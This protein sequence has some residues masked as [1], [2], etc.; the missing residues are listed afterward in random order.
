[1]LRELQPPQALPASVGDAQ[2]HDDTYDYDAFI[3]YSRKDRVF[4]QLL[5]GRLEAY[6]PPKSLGLPARPLRV[7]LDTSDIRGPDYNETIERELQRS[8][9]LI[10]VC[11]PAARASEFVQDEIRRFIAAKRAENEAPQI[12]PLLLQGIPNNEAKTPEDEARKAFPEALYEVATMPLAQSFL[13]FDPQRHKLDRGGYRDAWFAA[14]A[15]LLDVDRHELEERDA[16]RAARTRRIITG[17]TLFTLVV[18]SGLAVVAWVQRGEAIA[19]RDQ[20][21]RQESRALAA[22]AQSETRAGNAVNGM[23]LALRGMP[24]A[25]VGH[26]GRSSPRRGRR[27]WM[28]RR[29]QESCWSCAVMRIG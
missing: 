8:R 21:L 16:K 28:P 13:E 14:L 23:L 27:W 12:L 25:G 11:T 19:Q 20:A 22:L 26:R 4:A 17:V 24:T 15:A 3:S 7:F 18:V 5:E 10:V 9:T 2:Q 29:P 1:M 6:R